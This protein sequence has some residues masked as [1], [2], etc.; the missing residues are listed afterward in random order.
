M[1]LEKR[2]YFFD[3][4]DINIIKRVERR[5][6]LKHQCRRCHRWHVVDVAVSTSDRHDERFR[7]R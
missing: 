5:H 6:I 7:L 1:L 2:W 4:G 3:I